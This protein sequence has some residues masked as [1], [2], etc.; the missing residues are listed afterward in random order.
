MNR[1]RV[2]PVLLLKNGG[3]V[4]TIK[5]KKP[6]Y[7]GDPI[8]AV[9]IFNEKEVD[10]L[11]FLDIEATK[12]HN[13]PNYKIIEEIASE[14]FMP[15]AYG[16]GIKN[17]DQIKKIFNIGVEKIIINSVG[18]KNPDLITKAANIFGNQS[19]VVSV[20][21]KKDFFGK[22]RCFSN[23]GKTKVRQNMHDYLKMLENRGAGELILTSIEKEGTFG[24]YDIDLLKKVS[25][26]VNIPVVA[27]GGAKNIDD[28]INAVINGGASAV[29]AGSMFVY[30][31]TNKGVLI[32]YPSQN[33]LIEKLFNKIS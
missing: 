6:N 8:N 4:K 28:F 31:S 12:L 19:I 16:G 14:C 10:E 22:Y 24:G 23:S 7:I 21:V 2:I 27:N 3:L 11:V 25:H 32:N 15:L 1:I 9:K 30:K 13:E 20:D 17:I 5:F 18:Y 29:A 33:E 26:A